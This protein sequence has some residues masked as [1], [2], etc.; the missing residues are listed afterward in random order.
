MEGQSFQVNDAASAMAMNGYDKQK[1]KQQNILHYFA[2]EVFSKNLVPWRAPLPQ[3]WLE[4]LRTS[5]LEV[6][7]EISRT[8]NLLI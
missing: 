8:S 5:L 1:Q 4:W 7:L 6:E 2:R 3:R